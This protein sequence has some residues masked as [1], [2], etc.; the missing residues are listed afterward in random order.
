MRTEIGSETGRGRG[1][2]A[3]FLAALIIL[4]GRLWA[5][6]PL[7]PAGGGT[8][9]RWDPVEPV[10]ISV[11]RGFLSD[12]G[13]IFNA[14]AV[15]F[16]RSTLA[17]W[18]VDTASIELVEGEQ[19]PVDVD[20][21]NY[22]PF[23]SEAQAAGNP[24]IF[25]RD[26]SI[27]DDLFGAGS[28]NNILGFAQPLTAGP[29][30]NFEGGFAVLN[31]RS[32][33]LNQSGTFRRVVIHELGHL[34]GLDHSQGDLEIFTSRDLSRFSFLPVMFPFMVNSGSAEPRHDDRV[35]LSYM[36]P[37][38]GFREQTAT[39]EGRALRRSMGGLS[40]ANVVAV[41]I[42][43]DEEGDWIE[44]PEATVSVVSDFLLEGVGRFELPGLEPGPYLVFME[45]IASF[46][47]G[48]SSVGPFP[49]RF[50]E[51]PKDYFN[52]ENESATELDDPAEQVLLIAVEGETVEDILL[53]VNEGSN[54]LASL[55]DDDQELFT[56]PEGF[57]FPFF[58]QVYD[59]VTVNTDGNLTFGQG[60]STSTARDEERFL[61]GPPRIAPLFT[62]L[63]PSVEGSIQ[64]LFDGTSLVFQWTDV[65]EYTA[66]GIAPGNTF[67]ARL[68]PD[69]SVEFEYDQVKVTS[70][71]GIQAIV[72]M[73]PGGSS[74]SGQLDWS[75]AEIPVRLPPASLYEV[76]K[77]Y[78]LGGQTFDL[79]SRH[80]IVLGSEPDRELLFP[81]IELSDLRFTGIA[82][83][84]DY[85]KTAVWWAQAW[86]ADGQNLALERNPVIE[87]IG[88]FGQTAIL[89]RDLF[90][91]PVAETKKGWLRMSTSSPGLSAFFQIGNGVGGR[92]SR[93]DGGVAETSP[94]SLFIFTR[95]HQGDD[96]LRIGAVTLPAVTRFYLVN[97]NDAPL[98]ATLQLIRLDGTVLGQVAV[99]L[100]ARGFR[101]EE[102]DLLFGIEV[103]RDS[104]AV[105]QFDEPG[106]IAFSMI[107][108][109][110]ALFGNP[111]S[112][113]SERPM[114]YSAQLAH[115]DVGGVNLTTLVRVVNLSGESRTVELTSVD[116]DGNVVI[117]IGPF[118]VAPG[119][120]VE[121]DG[122]ELLG[123]DAEA[124]VVAGS[125][126]VSSDDGGIEG[127]VVFGETQSF[128]F[129]S[130]LPLQKQGF[131]SA[132]F[133]HIAS[134]S[135]P[136]PRD[137]M[138]TGIALFNPNPSDA[139]VELTVIG[140]E[141]V[142]IGRIQLVLKPGQRL[143]KVLSE[144]VPESWGRV[145]GYVLVQ[146]S[147]PLVGQEL[148][149]NVT[150]DYLS[151]VPPSAIAQ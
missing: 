42:D 117:G 105:L 142:P 118:E 138:F 136:D 79:E 60:D 137:S 87:S 66:F 140:S 86:A 65:P 107:Q 103:I 128:R 48:G 98:G 64:A 22:I 143:S 126:I 129:G 120:G 83:G 58:G 91:D 17:A 67:G 24:V 11:D 82:V 12:V 81:V 63:D 131:Q 68:F 56:F 69:G 34:L 149:G 4:S 26:G 5:G 15:D 52:G 85:R 124:T 25:D 20:S 51:F 80:I 73:T 9:S 110:D 36:Y 27:I 113:I 125:L 90:R 76:F 104:Y 147:L 89:A 1:I 127:D 23:I 122:A 10:V 78:S 39:I 119:A 53:Y 93:L 28:S 101:E 88:P 77:G 32:A 95:I 139:E 62:D 59:R 49:V 30:L 111:P 29:G 55:T 135:A 33:N 144:L 99:N 102:A 92:P 115:G 121:I 13:P 19:L 151:A 41:A 84:N 6:G 112:R 37:T 100:P 106:G 145:G 8:F 14:E 21:S 123:T 96:S 54:D 134:R 43:I 7:A 3:L 70:D 130:R 61:S 132:L 71:S 50:D 109:G 146:A 57:T 46:F 40:G 97:P 72:G 31:G 44:R 74:V 38:D 16:V 116:D 148:F 75:Q 2:R 114:A 141:G 35:W 94:A 108:A 18:E 133:G 47:T 150:L 45:P